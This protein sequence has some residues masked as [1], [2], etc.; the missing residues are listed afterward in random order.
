MPILARLADHVGSVKLQTAECTQRVSTK[1]N[2]R[3]KKEDFHGILPSCL[4]KF[5]GNEEQNPS[6]PVRK[7]ADLENRLA[8]D[9]Q[10][11]HRGWMIDL[12]S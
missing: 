9:C 12:K 6:L 1:N 2:C 8:A 7:P 5:A 11:E 4:G 3:I 10:G